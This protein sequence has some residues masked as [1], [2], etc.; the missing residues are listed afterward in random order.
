MRARVRRFRSRSPFSLPRR[1]GRPIRQ[2]NSG[3]GGAGERATRRWTPRRA[4]GT[5]KDTDKRARRVYAA[6][7]PL[8]SADRRARRLR[9][10]ERERGSAANRRFRKLGT[11]H[12][13]D[14][15]GGLDLHR[16]VDDVLDLLAEGMLLDVLLNGHVVFVRR[17]SDGCDTPCSAAVRD[18][19]SVCGEG[20]GLLREH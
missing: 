9:T 15:L 2:Y 20:D 5:L 19:R 13:R 1:P 17:G 11:H 16:G 4:S 7:A 6:K 3:R 18:A 8:A 12:E 10:T 14:G